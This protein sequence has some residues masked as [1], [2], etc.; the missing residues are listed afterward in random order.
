MQCFVVAILIELDLDFRTKGR[1][2]GLMTMSTVETPISLDGD[3][4]IFL[5]FN[6][7]D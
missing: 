4:C 7:S 1:I 5:D 3:D 2:V 6:I